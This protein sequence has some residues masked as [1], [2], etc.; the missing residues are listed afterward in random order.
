[1]ANLY[2]DRDIRPLL[3][4]NFTPEE[5]KKLCDILRE[6]PQIEAIPIKFIEYYASKKGVICQATL[7]NLIEEF[8]NKR[9]ENG[10]RFV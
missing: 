4:R 2:A 8:K 10:A 9:D 1:M 3:R 7:A 6:C 5:Y